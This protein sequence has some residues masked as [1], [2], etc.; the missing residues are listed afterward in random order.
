MLKWA[1]FPFRPSLRSPRRCPSTTGSGRRRCQWPSK[2]C[3]RRADRRV[4]L[5]LL[6]EMGDSLRPWTIS[7][8]KKVSLH[9]SEY[10]L[11]LFLKVYIH[12]M[13]VAEKLSTCFWLLLYSRERFIFT[14]FICLVSR[15]LLSAVPANNCWSDMHLFHVPPLLL[16][17]L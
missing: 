10:A 9:I 2:Y 4:V 15:W 12:L 5:A 14:Y 11:L 6:F 13:W 8:Q 17:G 16:F 3:V 7:K 1:L